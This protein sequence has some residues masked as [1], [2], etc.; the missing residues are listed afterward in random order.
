VRYGTFAR[1]LTVS[2]G[3]APDRVRAAFTN[4]VLEVTL[5][6]PPELTPHRVPIAI[7]GQPAKAIEA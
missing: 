2:E 6:L 3:I 5:P 4:G 7:E 1:T